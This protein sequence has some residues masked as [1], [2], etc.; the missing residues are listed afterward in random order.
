MDNSST[1]DVALTAND[2]KLVY[3]PPNTTAGY[4]P[5]DAGVI[6]VL[7]RRYKRRLLAFLLLLFPV[8][9]DSTPPSD[10]PP[11]PPPTPPTTP[12]STQPISP[13]SG[14]RP[15]PFGFRAEN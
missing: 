10:A 6:A 9:I 5:M 1:H 14:P 7:K 8:P 4:Q 3:L 15:A 13:P 12:S 2:D 11:R